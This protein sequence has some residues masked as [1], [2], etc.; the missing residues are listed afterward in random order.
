MAI[1]LFVLILSL[2]VFVHELGHFWAARKS[3]VGVLEFGFGF[4]PRIWGVKRGNTIYSINVIPFG[5]F[6]RLEGE[7]DGQTEAPDSFAKAP[8]KKKFGILA[9]GVVMNYLLAWVLLS[10]VLVAGT[11]I[12]PATLTHDRWQ[13]VSDQRVE[14]FVSTD[15][16]AELA[17]LRTSDTVISVNGIAFTNT[18]DLVAYTTEN[19]RPELDVTVVRD[20]KQQTIAISPKDTDGA[21]PA[22]G[23]GL[24]AYAKIT[25]P[26][27]VA[28]WYGLKT[29]VSVTGQTFT[30]FGKL[31]GQLVRTGKV[32][33]DVAG[34]V[35]IA[36]LTGQVSQLGAVSVLQFIAILSISLAVINF[37]PLPALDGGRATFVLI[38]RFRGKPVNPKIEG[39]IHATGFYL[40]LLLIIL[41]SIR[42]VQ[43]FDVL[44]RVRGLFK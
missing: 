23:F 26:W 16:Q 25:Y 13:R 30:G 6:V 9:A 18:D 12:D 32:A 39:A 20:G 37:L 36:V 44:D 17:G 14:A 11:N 38:E 24:L 35:G 40:L 2:L 8:L 5:G 4:P 19:N 33:E 28:P 21:T 15:S 43:R 42:D 3:G 10:A 34:P 41:I 7:T 22:Y 29:T 27:Y 31:I 1:L